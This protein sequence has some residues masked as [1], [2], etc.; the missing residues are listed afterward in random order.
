[1]MVRD[2]KALIGA[3]K[4]GAFEASD[5]TRYLKLIKNRTAALLDNIERRRT[6]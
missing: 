4:A 1:M 2:D 3:F 5:H 6:D